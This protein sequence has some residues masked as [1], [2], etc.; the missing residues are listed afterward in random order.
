M[1]RLT[2]YDI[3]EHPLYAAP[4]ALRYRKCMPLGVGNLS[5]AVLFAAVVE[6]VEQ[7]H[8]R[9]NVQFLQTR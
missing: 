4:L 5:V 8:L 6:L 1:E 3:P 2:L 9:H 7:P